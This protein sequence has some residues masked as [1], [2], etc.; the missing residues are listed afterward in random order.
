[1]LKK[2]WEMFKAWMTEEETET[3]PRWLGMLQGW[4][5]GAG[6]TT[7][8]YVIYSWLFGI[9]YQAYSIRKK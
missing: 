6:I 5:I 2:Y 7:W 4:F 9:R 8:W 3:K 1:M